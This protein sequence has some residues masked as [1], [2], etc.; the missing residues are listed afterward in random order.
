MTSINCEK[1]GKEMVKRLGKFGYFLFCPNQK[2][3]GQKTIGLEGQSSANQNNDLHY[4]N[5]VMNYDGSDLSHLLG[6]VMDDSIEDFR[7][8]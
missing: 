3:C 6:E 4:L 8:Y 5:R 1:C 2:G 7:P